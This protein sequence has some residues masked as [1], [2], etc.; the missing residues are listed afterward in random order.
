MQI[1]IVI[2]QLILRIYLHFADPIF[3]LHPLQP[4][5]TYAI[6]I[7]NRYQGKIENENVWKLTTHVDGIQVDEKFQKNIQLFGDM[8][9]YMDGSNTCLAEIEDPEFTFFEEGL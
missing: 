6:Q 2:P 4:N 8:W 3:V 1:Y 9:H 7:Q 5:R